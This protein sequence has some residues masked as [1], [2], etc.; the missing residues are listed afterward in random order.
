MIQGAANYAWNLIEEALAMVWMPA[1][2]IQGRVVR[3]QPDHIRRVE[4]EMR[5]V[6]LKHQTASDLQLKEEGEGRRGG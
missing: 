4:G 5:E 3:A 1:D 6:S 2:A